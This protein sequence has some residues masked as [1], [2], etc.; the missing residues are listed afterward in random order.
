MFNKRRAALMVMDIMLVVSLDVVLLN[1]AKPAA[2]AA[3]DGDIIVGHHHGKA[4]AESN[5]FRRK[6]QLQKI[7][8]NTGLCYGFSEASK[9]HRHSE[10]KVQSFSSHPP[11]LK[12]LLNL[13]I[14]FYFLFALLSIV[15]CCYSNF[16][17]G[18][19]FFCQ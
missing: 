12:I 2:S 15:Y 13:L 7:S 11:N 19:G 10:R 3:V 16:C 6:S 1:L 9:M 14:F 4:L 17:Y 5:R 18:E 8:G